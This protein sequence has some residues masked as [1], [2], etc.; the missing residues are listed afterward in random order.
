MCGSRTVLLRTNARALPLH[1]AFHTFTHDILHHLCS[2]CPHPLHILE[3][4]DVIS[5][6]QLIHHG[7]NGH[8]GPCAACSRTVARG[9]GSYHPRHGG[10]KF[11]AT[12]GCTVLW[13]H[14]LSMSSSEGGLAS[15]LVLKWFLVL[16]ATP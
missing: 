7:V 9:S 13:R 10:M 14:V 1:S 16:S 2:P 4:I 8:V 15:L 5:L 3:Y 6:L 12:H 11:Y